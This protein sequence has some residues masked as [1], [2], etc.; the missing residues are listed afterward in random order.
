MKM[1]EAMKIAAIGER[2]KGY[3]VSFERVE[4]HV[5]CSDHFPERDEQPIGDLSEAWALAEA[6]AEKTVGKCVN[7]YVVTSA[8][9]PV[10]GYRERRIENR[11]AKDYYEKEWLQIAGRAARI[12]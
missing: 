1:A 10:V 2:P 7:I 9:H 3:R 11:V 4:G 5:L 6:F 12:F 8:F